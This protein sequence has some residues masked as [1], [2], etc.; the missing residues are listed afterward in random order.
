MLISTNM[1]ETKNKHI[2]TEEHFSSKTLVAPV[3]KL[4]RYP[5]IIAINKA[6]EDTKMFNVVNCSGDIFYLA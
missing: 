4:A 3:V 2:K 6:T 1:N 5:V